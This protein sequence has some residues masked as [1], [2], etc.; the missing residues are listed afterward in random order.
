[1]F[2]WVNKGMSKNYFNIS[3]FK[4]TSMLFSWMFPR[5]IKE[6]N[7]LITKEYQFT[8]IIPIEKNWR[9]ENSNSGRYN[10]ILKLL[11]AT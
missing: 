5:A 6:I 1:M 7:W 9:S 4:F 10:W 3:Y 2:K 11:V 8:E